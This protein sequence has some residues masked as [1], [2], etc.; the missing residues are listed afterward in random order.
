METRLQ[1]ARQMH[2]RPVK[3]AGFIGKNCRAIHISLTMAG[4]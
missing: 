2:F 1:R 4:A 3:D